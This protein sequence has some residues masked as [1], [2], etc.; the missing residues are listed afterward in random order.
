LYRVASN[1][2]WPKVK[3]SNIPTIPNQKN[4]FG[5]GEG[6]DGSLIQQLNSE[7]TFT[8][9]PNDSVGPGQCDIV[10][11]MRRMQGGNWDASK[12]KRSG[13]DQNKAFQ[14]PVGPGSYDTNTPQTVNNFN[15]RG[16]SCF[17]S[18]GLKCTVLKDMG[19]SDESVPGP[20]QYNPSLYEQ[21]QTQGTVQMFGIVSPRFVEEKRNFVPGP[22]KY[23]DFRQNYV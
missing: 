10:S 14:N 16:T 5:Y 19:V 1:T 6:P 4:S 20:G 3:L 12:S 9:L 18:N 8:G 23:G 17:I 11:T 13:L 2:Q 22:G 21:R 7:K 15:T